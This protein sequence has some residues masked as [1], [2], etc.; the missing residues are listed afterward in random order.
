MV[1]ATRK[2][3]PSPPQGGAGC[4]LRFDSPAPR[5]HRTSRRSEKAH[6]RPPG[7]TASGRLSLSNFFLPDLDVAP[8]HQVEEYPFRLCRYFPSE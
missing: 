3:E 2:Q 6:I 4:P 7:S 1:E 8:R 5:Y